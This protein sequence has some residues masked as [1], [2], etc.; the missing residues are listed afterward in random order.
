VSTL[1][2]SAER[3]STTVSCAATIWESSNTHNVT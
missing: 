2:P 1:T 3:V